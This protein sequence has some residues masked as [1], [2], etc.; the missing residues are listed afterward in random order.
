VLVGVFCTADALDL[1]GRAGA[2]GFADGGTGF[3][4]AGAGGV[5][6]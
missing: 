4:S 1:A 2:V 3:S 5:S 6:S